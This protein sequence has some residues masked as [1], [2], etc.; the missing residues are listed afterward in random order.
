M[1]EDYVYGLIIFYWW[2]LEAYLKMA[3]TYLKNEIW[4]FGIFQ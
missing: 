4:C 1:N 2:F 3:M